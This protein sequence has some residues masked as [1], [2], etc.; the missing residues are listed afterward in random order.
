[1]NVLFASVKVGVFHASQCIYD[2]LFN[3]FFVVFGDYR[4]KASLTGLILS[5]F[6][7]FNSLV[8]IRGVVWVCQPYLS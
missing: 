7:L 6:E 1:M 8:D 4:T 3:Q 2:G 5:L